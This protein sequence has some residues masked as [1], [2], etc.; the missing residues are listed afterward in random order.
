MLQKIL[1]KITVVTQKLLDGDLFK[2]KILNSF[3]ETLSIFSLTDY[4][5]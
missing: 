4:T 1:S 5:Y 3:N 2:N